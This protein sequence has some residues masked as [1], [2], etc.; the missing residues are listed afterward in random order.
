MKNAIE[1]VA[2]NF[3]WGVRGRSKQKGLF[4]LSG[5]DAI[6]AKLELLDKKLSKLDL[7]TKLRSQQMFL[8]SIPPISAV[9]YVMVPIMMLHIVVARTLNI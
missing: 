9:I 5:V 7:K 3:S 4:E 1:E 8:R 2:K 6:N